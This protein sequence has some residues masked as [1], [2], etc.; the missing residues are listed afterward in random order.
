MSDR[1][2]CCPERAQ[3]LAAEPVTRTAAGP[4][5]RTPADPAPPLAGPGPLALEHGS[6]VVWRLRNTTGDEVGIERLHNA[7]E[8]VRRPFEALPVVIPPNGAVDITLV[9][10]WGTRC[11]R[12]SR[13]P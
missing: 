10:V 4:A 2:T 3:A 7:G 6:G 1:I 8:F 9:A 12:R 13:W 11:R 5:T